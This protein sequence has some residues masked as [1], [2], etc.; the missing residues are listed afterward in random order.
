MD[1]SAA[2][3]PTATPQRFLDL[4]ALL[5]FATALLTTAALLAALSMIAAPV[6]TAAATVAALA[7]LAQHA[8]RTFTR[9]PRPE[10]PATTH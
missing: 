6:V 3:R 7:G 10:H 9:H 8:H 5:R 2:D 4:P 1:P